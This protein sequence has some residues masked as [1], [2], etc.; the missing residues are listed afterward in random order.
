MSIEQIWSAVLPQ[1]R[2]FQGKGLSLDSISLRPLAWYTTNPQAWVRS[3]LIEAKMGKTSQT[4]HVLVGY[5]PPGTGESDALIGRYD[6]PQRGLVDVVDACRS[7]IAMQA[8]LTAISSGTP[9]MNWVANPVDPGQRTEVFSAEQSNTTVLI[10]E[11]V[12]FKVIRRVFSGRNPEVELLAGL[13]GSGVT[14]QLFGTL[15]TPD[16]SY[17]LGLFSQRITE[18]ID[19]WDYCVHACRQNKSVVDQMTALGSTL[20]H[21]HAC[22]AQA[23]G[24][25]ITDSSQISERMLA[26][27][28][29]GCHQIP[30][31]DQMI[32]KLRS[33]LILPPGE[34]E[35][36]RVHGDFHLGQTLLSPQ[37]WTI[38]DFEGEPSKPLQDRARP[39][40]VFSDVAG[41]TRSLDYVRNHH[42]DPESTPAQ[43][44]FAQARSAFLTGYLGSS[45]APAALTV[46]E[47][48][49][50]VYELIYETRNRP[51]WVKI[52]LQAIETM[53]RSI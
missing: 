9:G 25:T 39:Y 26:R 20:Q 8:F 32:E 30:Q 22:L 28:Q 51:N 41:L 1:A 5:L 45:L 47:I 24:R 27:L 11:Q 4:Y 18:S 46:Y 3:E 10:G 37:G 48:D 36:Q 49:K 42:H 6:L 14:P 50:A 16:G 38:I 7:G 23:F 31:L 15:S 17:D 35:T 33:L 43:Q 34:T 53:I 13:N 21:L 29:D 52:P 12:L 19:G 40:S 2:W 44:W